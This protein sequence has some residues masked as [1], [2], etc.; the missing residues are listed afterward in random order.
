MAKSPLE[1]W[2]DQSTDAE[3]LHHLKHYVKE[4]E[5]MQNEHHVVL[6]QLYSYQ[7]IA[8]KAD[9]FPKN[10]CT[11]CFLSVL[12]SKGE[13]WHCALRQDAYEARK[14]RVK[15]EA[16]RDALA[17]A[18]IHAGLP[19]LDKRDLDN[20]ACRDALYRLDRQANAALEKS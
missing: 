18:I 4:F 16:E 19:S 3:R 8:K 17:K 13:C 10:V 9:W 20:G 6:D 2:W 5:S 15:A 12:T 11:R 14:A 1:K 7:E